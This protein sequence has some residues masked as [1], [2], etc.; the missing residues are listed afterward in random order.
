MLNFV[1]ISPNYMD[2]VPP[3][4]S[5]FVFAGFK[6]DLFKMMGALLAFELVSPSIYRI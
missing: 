4:T 2:I 3:S 6:N 5:I 1:V